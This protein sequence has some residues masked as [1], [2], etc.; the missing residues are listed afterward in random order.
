MTD[1]SAIG[2]IV[3]GSRHSKIAGDFGEALLLYWLSRSGHE[4]CRVDHTGIDLLSYD[5]TSDRRMGISV[6]CRT[7]VPGTEAEGVY[8]RAKEFPLI[9]AACRA[10]AAEPFLGI[11]VDRD[12]RI[13][14]HL[15][16]LQTAREVNGA[17]SS[18]LLNFKVTPRHV[19]QYRASAGYVGVSFQYGATDAAR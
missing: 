2:S 5:P 16:S 6:K 3:K 14:A 1:S 15:V 11:V 9:E 10:Y 7:R 4:V 13:E 12:G 18:T 17:R 8:I 19:D